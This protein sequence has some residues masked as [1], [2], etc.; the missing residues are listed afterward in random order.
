MQT[1]FVTGAEGFAGNLLTHHLRQRGYSVVAGVR[2]RARKLAYEREYGKAI[3]CDVSDA[4]NVA[5]AVASARPDGV[6]HLAGCSHPGTATEQPL[7][8]YQSTVT[9]WANVLDAVRRICPRARVLLISAC[10]VYGQAGRD[11]H[12][13]SEDTLPQPASAFGSL[14]L[15]AESIAHTYFKSCHLNLTI[16]RPFHYTGPGQPDS[17]FFGAVARQLAQWDTNTQG[18]ELSLPD[19]ACRRDLLHVYDVVDAYERLLRDGR[20]NETYNV[21]SGESRTCRQIVEAMAQTMRLPIRFADQPTP[22]DA[23][24][25]PVFRGDNSKLRTELGWHP[26]RTVDGAVQDLM[27]SYRQPAP[28]PA[29]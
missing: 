26:T 1:V 8:T 15:A 5:R 14:K 24:F 10:D 18:P 11:G 12:P 9:A 25:V 7:A 13:V 6:V 27:R 28:A 22:A 21:C 29:R 2:N 16:A 3:V 20:P 4:I 23:D 17:F 19:L